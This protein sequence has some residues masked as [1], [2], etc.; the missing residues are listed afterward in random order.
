[1]YLVSGIKTTA[2]RL[3]SSG[4]GQIPLA[5]GWKSTDTQRNQVSLFTAL[6]TASGKT[7]TVIAF[8]A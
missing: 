1:M 6:P 4:D 8:C 2:L 7:W 3:P 5:A